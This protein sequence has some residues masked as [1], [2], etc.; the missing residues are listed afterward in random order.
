M[1]GEEAFRTFAVDP[2]YAARTLRTQFLKMQADQ[3]QQLAGGYAKDWGDYQFRVGYIA[4]LRAAIEE[5]DAMEKA[6][7]N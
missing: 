2:P 3:A 6:E 7:N 1:M 4:G 5:C